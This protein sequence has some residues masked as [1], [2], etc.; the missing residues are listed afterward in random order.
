[1]LGNKVSSFL[2]ATMQIAKVP[3]SIIVTLYYGTTV[4]Y[5]VCRPKC[6]YTSHDCNVQ[7]TDGTRVCNQNSTCAKW[8]IW[9]FKVAFISLYAIKRGK[10][11]IWISK[12]YYVYSV[13]LIPNSIQGYGT[14]H[15]LNACQETTFYK[16]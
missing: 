3:I 13:P 14:L 9:K 2:Y 10:Y 6:R 15:S 8:T 4:I 7:E 16:D 1:M 12:H 11:L 5:V